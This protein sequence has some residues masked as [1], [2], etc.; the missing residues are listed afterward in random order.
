MKS[1]KVSSNKLRQQKAADK[2]AELAEKFSNTVYEQS[3]T[4]KPAAESGWREDRAE[5]MVDQ[6][7]GCR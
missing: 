1:A 5:R 3:D 6:R 7:G 2:F 4:L